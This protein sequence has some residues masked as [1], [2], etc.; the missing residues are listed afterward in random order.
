MPQLKWI[1]GALQKVGLVNSLGALIDGDNPLSVSPSASTLTDYFVSAS[2]GDISGVTPFY[3]Y[4][5]NP[6]IS[7]TTDPEDIWNGGSDYTG[8]PTGAAEQMEIF[9]SSA[10]DTIT[11]TGARTVTIFN[12]MDSTGAALPDIT[13][14]LDGT[15]PVSLGPLSYYRGGTLMKVI[16]AGSGGENAGTLTL[17]HVT[18]TANVFAVMPTGQNHTAIGARTVPLGKTLLARAQMGMARANGSPGSATM[19]L[20]ARE[21]GKVFQA[22]A[23]P[24]ISHSRDYTSLRGVYFV[25]P[26]RS[27]IKFRCEVVSDNNTI[28]TVE[29]NGILIDNA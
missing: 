26:E 18:T 17:R 1:G 28:V 5:K 4:G 20:R 3:M 29:M 9:S 27:D 22:I 25:F 24:E 19:T 6:S 7:T 13:V 21:N 16:T 23:N 14:D 12:L 8:F 2:Q 11:G 15:T 10:L